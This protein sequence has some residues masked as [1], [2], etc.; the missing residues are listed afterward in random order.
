MR[1]GVCSIMVNE[2]AK[3][4]SSQQ[5]SGAFHPNA[6]SA[7]RRMLT[8]IIK[9]LLFILCGV[10][11][12]VLAFLMAE[13][14]SN[15]YI[16]ASEGMS[17]RMECIVN[18]TPDEEELSDYFL[19]SALAQDEELQDSAFANYVISDENYSLEI[20]GISVLPWSSTAKVTAIES[21]TVKGSYNSDRLAS[22]ETLE[23][24]PLPEWPTRKLSISFYSNGS[25]WYISGIEVLEVNPKV[26]A[27]NTPD[28]EATVLPMATP[29]PIPDPTPT[30]Q[31]KL[32]IVG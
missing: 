22:G 10:L 14:C 30:P 1:Y 29:T 12:C 5:G 27:L 24:H 19:A 6:L 26:D 28:P 17:L 9:I 23:D 21:V 3:Q 8:Y 18:N 31:P 4:S 25:R 2:S 20:K 7:A 32:E 11:I 13:R 16:L 15:L